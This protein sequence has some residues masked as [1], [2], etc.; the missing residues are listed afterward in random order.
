MNKTT[1]KKQII[2]LINDSG[3]SKVF[4]ISSQYYKVINKKLVPITDIEAIELL[5]SNPEIWS[6]QI[7]SKVWSWKTEKFL[8][9][10]PE[11]LPKELE[12]KKVT[13]IVVNDPESINTLLKLLRLWETK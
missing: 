8:G 12:G 9:S 2:D 7:S 10:E 13:E 5:K 11:P 4:Y 6:I 3:T 1:L